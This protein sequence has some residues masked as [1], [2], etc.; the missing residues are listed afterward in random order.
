MVVILISQ[1]MRIIIIIL[2]SISSDR[3]VEHC[4]TGSSSECCKVYVGVPIS[5]RLL[6]V[7]SLTSRLGA[8]ATQ[9]KEGVD[10]WRVVLSMSE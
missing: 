10:A 7:H 6:F 1:T 3:M 4:F 9:R 8:Q 5:L 2:A